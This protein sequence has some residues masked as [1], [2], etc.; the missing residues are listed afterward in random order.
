MDE[1]FEIGEIL[2]DFENDHDEVKA[3]KN[4]FE[5]IKKELADQKF[6]AIK[7]VNTVGTLNEIEA[8]TYSIEAIKSHSRKR[9][10]IVD[11]L[12]EKL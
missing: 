7:I 6:R 12:E 5:E 2:A 10:A 3:V 9:L 1:R 8:K 11:A 4:I